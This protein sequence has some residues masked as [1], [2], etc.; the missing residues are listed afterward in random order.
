[1]SFRY[2]GPYPV[3]RRIGESA[4]ELLLPSHFTIHNVFHV[5]LLKK[6]VPNDQHILQ[7]DDVSFVSQGELHMEPEAILEHRER[8]LRSRHIHEVL[9]KWKF[10]PEED[11]SWEDWN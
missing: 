4:Y 6:Y 1:M 5:S 8:P 11:A 7:D 9:V 10:Y 2:C 3:T